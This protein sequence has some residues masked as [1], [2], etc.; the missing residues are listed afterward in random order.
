VPGSKVRYAEGGGPDPRCYRVD[1]SKL[2]RTLPEY[3]P[4][5][6]VREGMEQLREAFERNGLTRDELLGDK[7]FPHQAAAG[8]AG[9]WI[10]RRFPAVDFR[11]GTWS[12]RRSAHEGRDFLRRPRY[13]PSRSW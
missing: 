6:T 13:A 1:C 8:A 2:M 12:S 7:Y 10:H 4:E 9:G 11:S 3:H 5:W